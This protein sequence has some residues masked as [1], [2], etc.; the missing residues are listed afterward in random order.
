MLQISTYGDPTEVVGLVEAPEPGNPKAN[1]A[2]VAVEYSPI[3]NSDLLTI[4]GRYGVRPA[5]PSGLGNEGVGRIL[6]VGAG[7]TTSNGSVSSATRC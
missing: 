3:N 1:E 4:R 2:L 7:D 6:T 5:L